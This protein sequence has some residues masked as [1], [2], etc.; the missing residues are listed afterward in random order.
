MMKEKGAITIAQ[1]EESCVCLPECRVEAV[2][3]MPPP[4]C[5]LRQRL[6]NFLRGC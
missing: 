4:T 2:N 6:Q 1:D 3:L 5:F